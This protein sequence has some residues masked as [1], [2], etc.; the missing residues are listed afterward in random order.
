MAF[1]QTLLL[2]RR[3]KGLASAEAR[4][5][6]A[7]LGP[8]KLARVMTALVLRCQWQLGAEDV[9]DPRCEGYICVAII[10]LSPESCSS[11]Y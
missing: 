3:K 7:A 8:G 11:V 10:S 4:L 1:L 9:L 2:H 6:A 5:Q